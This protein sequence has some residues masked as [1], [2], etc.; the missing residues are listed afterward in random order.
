MSGSSSNHRARTGAFTV[1]VSGDPR[2]VDTVRTLTRKAAEA[3]GCAGGD[4]ARLAEAVERVLATLFASFRAPLVEGVMDVRF[5][6]TRHAFSVE[7]RV[8]ALAVASA[9]GTLERSLAASG[10]LDAVRT[11]AP[12]AEFGEAGTHLFCRIAC[13]HAPGSS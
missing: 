8:P 1:T 11:L 13:L 7:I 12:G 2:F 6:P 10:G 5:E 9:G 3:D 4:A